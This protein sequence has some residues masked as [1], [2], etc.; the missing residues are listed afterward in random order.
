MDENL[1]TLLLERW[2]NMAALGY[3]REAMRLA[4]L[5]QDQ[6][7]AVLDEMEWLFDTMTLAEAEKALAKTWKKE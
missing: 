7:E 5:S 1:K 6:A 2:S 3:A 4:G